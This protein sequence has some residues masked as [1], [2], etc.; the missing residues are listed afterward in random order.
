MTLQLPS[1][2]YGRY[3]DVRPRL[4]RIA[5]RM[6]RGEEWIPLVEERGFLDVAS[7]PGYIVGGGPSSLLGA[8]EHFQLWLL[9]MLARDSGARERRDV[10]AL[11]GGRGSNYS[12]HALAGHLSSLSP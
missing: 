3:R 8:E 7:R 10:G 4:M 9:W 1:I 11:N 6:C 5:R 2:M 12:F